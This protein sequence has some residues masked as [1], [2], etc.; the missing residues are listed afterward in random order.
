METNE[1]FIQ[2]CVWPGTNCTE[3]EAKNFENFMFET[4]L[5]RVKYKCNILTNPDIDENGNPIPNTGGR[6]DLFFYVHTEDIRI[7]A[8][9]RLAY[10][11]RWWEDVIKYNNNTHLYPI[12]FIEQNPPRW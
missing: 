4:F 9:K 8:I 10:G 3:K 12:K 5:V 2:L 7:F 1:N 11:I 6:N